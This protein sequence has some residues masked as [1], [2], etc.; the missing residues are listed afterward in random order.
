MNTKNTVKQLEIDGEAYYIKPLTLRLYRELKGKLKE[1][2]DA[3]ENGVMM[4]AY[5]LCNTDGRLIY[6]DTMVD[7]INDL[8]LKVV[9]KLVNEINTLNGWNDVDIKKN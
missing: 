4:V 7:A 6:N 9:L 5:S 2:V 8:P 3:E 1:N